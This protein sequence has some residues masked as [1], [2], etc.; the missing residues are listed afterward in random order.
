MNGNSLTATDAATAAP[1]PWVASARWDL[2][3]ILLS[4]LLVPLPVLLHSWKLG[5]LGI[6]L[7]VTLLI[8]GPHMY[9]TFLRTTFDG[10]FRRRH[11]ALTWGPVVVIPLFVLGLGLT[12]FQW[13]LSL[14][15]TWASLHI[16]DQAS[17]IAQLY[18]G[19]RG[20]RDPVRSRS[21]LRGHPLFALPLRHLPLRRRDVPHRGRHDLLPRVPQGG[22]GAEGL[23]DR[24]AALLSFWAV[25]TINQLRARQVSM[26]YVGFMVL[27]MGISV[28][29]PSYLF[30]NELSVTFQGFNAWHSFQY[31]GLTFLA[32]N[33]AGRRREG[34]AGVPRQLA[35]P[36]KSSGSTGGTSSS[37]SAPG[38]SSSGSRTA[39]A[40]RPS[41]AITSSSSPSCSC[42]T[43]TT[44]CCSTRRRR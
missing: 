14:F 39:P 38:A 15:F 19:G 42:T 43:S 27:T 7:L 1:T 33:R 8:G 25:R 9:A 32:L 11:P 16:C 13:L 44:A 6:D 41:S 2:S 4:A 18:R 22:L 12:R 37:P 17:Y 10:G 3:W 26:Q 28:L 30:E 20:P 31:L 23:R 40:S 29:V 24:Q 21:R 36:G 35:A 34:D 5:P